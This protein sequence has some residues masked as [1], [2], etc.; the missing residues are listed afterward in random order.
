MSRTKVQFCFKGTRNYIHGTD[1]FDKCL[2]LVSGSDGV[3]ERVDMSIHSIIRNQLAV[4]PM[5]VTKG[6][7]QVNFTCVT[8]G[9]ARTVYLMETDEPVNCRYSYEE[10][11]IVKMAVIDQTAPSISV[12]GLPEFSF[13][14]KAVAL[15]KALLTAIYKNTPGKWYFTRIKLHD[16]SFIDKTGDI[17]MKVALRRNLD[18]KITDSIVSVEGKDI[19][20]IYFSLV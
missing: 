20:N 13:I 10:D 12:A 4:V 8:A 3:P 6:K 19:G 15:N 18:F 9:E 17:D 11:D 7:F 5:N 16:I 14:E 1:I 2:A